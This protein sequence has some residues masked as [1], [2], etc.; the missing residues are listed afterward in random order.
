MHVLIRYIK[1][2]KY[3][4]NKNNDNN[5]Q[6]LHENLLSPFFKSKGNIYD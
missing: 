4:N 1:Y 2:E 3:N 6:T 5:N